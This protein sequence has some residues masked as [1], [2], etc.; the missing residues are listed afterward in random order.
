MTDVVALHLSYVGADG[1]D[2]GWGGRSSICPV[3][4]KRRLIPSAALENAPPALSV[5]SS[6]MGWVDV[7]QKLELELDTAVK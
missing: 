2:H 3:A 6:P 1:E 7:K 4:S 5:S